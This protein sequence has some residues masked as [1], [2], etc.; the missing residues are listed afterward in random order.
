MIK[1]ELAM[2]DSLTTKLWAM[3]KVADLVNKLI[4]ASAQAF[5]DHAQELR[6]ST[7]E[8]E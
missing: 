7:G 2:K 5:E 6:E 4:E 8:A 3:E 1:M